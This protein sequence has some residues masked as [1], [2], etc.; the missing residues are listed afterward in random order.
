MWVI[1]LV[2]GVG[3]GIAVGIGEGWTDPKGDRFF[4]GLTGGGLGYFLS[5]GLGLI[6]VPGFRGNE[7]GIALLS[8]V[9]AL[10]FS[11]LASQ[12]RAR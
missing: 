9:F 12:I 4:H 5:L 11:F 3:I 6:G 10:A 2:A 1:L 8:G 7:V